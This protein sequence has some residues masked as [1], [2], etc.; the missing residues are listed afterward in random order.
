[1]SGVFYIGLS[2]RFDRDKVQAYPPGS[3]LVP[4]RAKPGTSIEANTEV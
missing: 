4:S 2:D 1:M 3:F